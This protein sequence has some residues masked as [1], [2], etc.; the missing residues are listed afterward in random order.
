MQ[1]IEQN[2]TFPNVGVPAAI[3]FGIL[4]RLYF[5][6][7]GDNYDLNSYWIVSEIVGRGGSVYAETFRYNYGPIWF[8]LLDVFRQ[9][10]KA[11]SLDSI[12]SLHIAIAAFLTVIDLLLARYLHKTF[13]ISTALFFFLNPISILI[14]GYHSQFDNLAILIGLFATL[15]MQRYHE[16]KSPWALITAG[17]ILGVSL[18]TK[19]IFLFFPLWLWWSLSGTRFWLRSTIVIIPYVTFALSFVPFM[20]DSA[21]ARGV[22]NNVI[23]YESSEGSGLFPMSI[24]FLASRTPVGDSQISFISKMIFISAILFAGLIVSS[25]CRTKSAESCARPS[26]DLMMRMYLLTLVGFSP[27]MADQYLAIPLMALA[28]CHQSGVFWC[29][30]LAG[31]AILLTS[32]DN[33][34]SNTYE[35]YDV[36]GYLVPQIIV[37]VALF[38]TYRSRDIHSPAQ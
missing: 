32:V 22:L 24:G 31:M 8:L 17:A 30:I 26:Y 11:I 38:K 4:A 13:G 34:F 16:T 19:H 36:I 29:Y 23:R 1:P 15:V 3:I 7:V 28:V 27:V 10:L 35:K 12:H 2:R 33:V 5:S 25:L 21:G 9:V 37:L 14:T 20:L 18:T 6:S